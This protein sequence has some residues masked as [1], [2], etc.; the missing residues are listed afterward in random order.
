M[1][2]RQKRCLIK[3]EE[4]YERKCETPS[5][6]LTLSVS[7]FEYTLHENAHFELKCL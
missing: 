4:F 5:L 7:P 6:L 1:S 2:K 3:L